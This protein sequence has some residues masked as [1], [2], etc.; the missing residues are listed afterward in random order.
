MMYVAKKVVGPVWSLIFDTLHFWEGGI[1]CYQCFSLKCFALKISIKYV[2][3]VWVHIVVADAVILFYAK[4]HCVLRSIVVR[5]FISLFRNWKVY[6]WWKNPEKYCKKNFLH[7]EFEN[8]S[9]VFFFHFSSTDGKGSFYWPGHFI[10][11]KPLYFWRV[12]YFI[13]STFFNM[14]V[15][16]LLK[17]FNSL[18]SLLENEIL[19]VL[20]TYNRFYKSTT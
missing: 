8:R 17:T 10:K 18:V 12:T 6:A 9:D 14:C 11:H 3:R 15:V 1:R 13:C 5:T 4:R 16:H 2:H 7:L 19:K 20:W